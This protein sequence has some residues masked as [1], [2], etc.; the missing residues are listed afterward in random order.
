MN[1]KHHALE[2]LQRLREYTLEQEELKLVQRQREEM[3]KEQDCRASLATLTE[4]YGHSV[5]GARVHDYARRDGC[6]R[7]AGVRHTID[8]R[9]LAIAQIARRDQIQATLQAKT[10]VDMVSKVLERRHTEDRA[11]DAQRERKEIEDAVQNR[12][13]RAEREENS[14]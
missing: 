14:I 9:Q 1:S 13:L 8:T 10:R 6:I 7:E 5:V 2:M 12:F 4:S 11:E 3:K